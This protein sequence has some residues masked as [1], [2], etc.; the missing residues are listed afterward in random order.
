MRLGSRRAEAKLSVEM[1]ERT[2]AREL[3][4][5]L[6]DRAGA[7][8]LDDAEVESRLK[9][10]LARAGEIYPDVRFDPALFARYVGERFEDQRQL[11]PERLADLYLAAAAET[12]DA[13]A[14]SVFE[15][16][17]LPALGPALDRLRLTHFERGDLEQR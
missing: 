5:A 3:A 14:I 7:V 16:R 13:A 8:S 10:G 11:T 12:G 15:H 17:I 2:L 6:G 1:A 9:A 4:S